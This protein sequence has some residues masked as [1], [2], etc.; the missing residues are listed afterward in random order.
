MENVKIVKNAQKWKRLMVRIS[1]V[2]VV[3]FCLVCTILPCS[4]YMFSPIDSDVYAMPLD[5]F[6]SI[7]RKL[8]GVTQYELC[9]HLLYPQ[10]DADIDSSNAWW[11]TL[12]TDSGEFYYVSSPIAQ[13][14][15][16]N[17]LLSIF[18]V[19]LED[20]YFQYYREE[21]FTL[22][23][24]ASVVE[25]GVEYCNLTTNPGS[26]D[27][28]VATVEFDYKIAGD[29]T[30]YHYSDAVNSGNY[31]S[32]IPSAT[33]LG[34]DVGELV[35]IYNYYAEIEFYTD[36]NNV[37]DIYFPRL[38]VSSITTE[39]KQTNTT[40]FMYDNDRI[41]SAGGGD[42]EINPGWLMQSV[43]S[44]FDFQIFPGFSLGGVMGIVV[45]IA[46]VIA[47]LKFVAG[48]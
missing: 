34:V 42:V 3:V 2:L 20:D 31:V 4:A 39:R 40:L 41:L 18:S 27:Y 37:G 33:A 29:T 32:L 44:F 26:S 25:M 21:R 7:E 16:G 24:D 48:G 1:A 46:V 30:K 19:C 10:L 17:R 11:T 23:A 35:Y 15:V 13:S 5:F 12:E 14:I 38:D 47:V 43:A 9:G 28:Y 22:S 8:A 6:F 36:V 45:S